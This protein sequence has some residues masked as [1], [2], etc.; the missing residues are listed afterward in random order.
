MNQKKTDEKESLRHSDHPRENWKDAEGIQETGN[1][2]ETLSSNEKHLEDEDPKY[3]EPPGDGGQHI[4][5][6][7]F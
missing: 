5:E 7:S 6:N 2:D 4:K 3:D 1:N